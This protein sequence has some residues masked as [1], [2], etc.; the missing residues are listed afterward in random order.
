MAES[1]HSK[2]SSDR[3]KDGIVKLTSH[4]LSLSESLHSMTINL[5]E[6]IQRL[7]APE[8]SSSSPLFTNQSPP[9]T[10]STSHRMKLDVPC[11]DGTDPL[12]WIFK[13][14]QFFEYH[15]TLDHERLTIASFYMDSHVL[16]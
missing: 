1:T 8:S 13:I 7:P 10:A 2:V 15:A 5:D 12:G 9:A 6:L 4:Q 14:N 3:L 11:F 16:A